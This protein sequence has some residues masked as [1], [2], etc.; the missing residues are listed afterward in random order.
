MGLPAGGTEASCGGLRRRG[1]AAGAHHE[2]Q[3]RPLLLELSQN[4]VLPHLR[5]KVDNLMKLVPQ[6]DQT[7]KESWQAQRRLLIPEADAAQSP[8][9]PH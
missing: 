6:G 5:G 8:L 2:V 7:S 1:C 9:C 4:C 3:L